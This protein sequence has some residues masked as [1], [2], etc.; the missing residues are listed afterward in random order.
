MDIQD[1]KL[2][3]KLIARLMQSNAISKSDRKELGSIQTS[4]GVFKKLNDKQRQ[5]VM[6]LCSKNMDI[7]H[8][9]LQK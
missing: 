1:A 5:K 4:L 7:V 3:Q 9:L 2:A 8:D 6:Q